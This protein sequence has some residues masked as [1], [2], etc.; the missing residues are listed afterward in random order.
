[1][2]RSTVD[3]PGDDRAYQAISEW[4]ACETPL[5]D[6]SWFASARPVGTD[7]TGIDE[8][9]MNTRGRILTTW[10]DLKAAVGIFQVLGALGLQSSFR[11]EDSQ[12][13]GP[14]PVHG[15][16]NPGAFRIDCDRDWWYCHTRCQSGG[17]VIALTYRLCGR[18]W[19]RTAR[20]LR[21]LAGH[22][23]PTMGPRPASW[24]KKDPVTSPTS[25]CQ[26]PFLPFT[27]RLPLNPISPFFDDL[28]LRPDTLSFF[29]AGA[30]AG[31]GFLE[32]MVALRLHDNDGNPLGYAGRRLDPVKIARHGKWKLPA[33][34]PKRQIL[35]SWHRV[36]N[37]LLRGLILVEGPWDLMKLHQAGFSNTVALTGTFLSPHHQALLS[38]A[39][40]LTLFFD[41]DAV[42]QRATDQM[43]RACI[44]PRLELIHCPVGR[45]P[46]QLCEEELRQLLRPAGR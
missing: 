5:R 15:G 43:H 7:D 40:K 32:G 23:L 6:G 20:L 13:V 44:H 31:Q 10:K 46:A 42:G 30:W 14:C 16:D 39:S 17:D 36:Q 45:D 3:S 22:A 2:G 12:W 28:G 34:F 9:T 35:Y 8:A 24:I 19:P 33:R 18:S 26:R 25:P 41:G 11:R 21:N 38:R 29:E 4:M 37:D 1:M 27:R